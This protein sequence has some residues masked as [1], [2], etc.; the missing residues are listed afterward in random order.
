MIEGGDDSRIDKFLEDLSICAFGKIVSGSGSKDRA[1]DDNR[2]ALA[3]RRY[4]T[5][6]NGFLRAP[7]LIFELNKERIKANELAAIAAFST[8]GD[9]PEA[10]Q[11][12]FDLLQGQEDYDS[13]YELLFEPAI[14]DPNKEY[15]EV[16][17][18]TRGVAF[19]R[20]A[21]GEKVRV[22]GMSGEK[23]QVYVAWF[24][25]A[26]GVTEQAIRYRDL[27]GLADMFNAFRDAYQSKRCGDFYG[28]INDAGSNTTSLDTADVSGNALRDN[29]RLINKMYSTL[30]RRFYGQPGYGSATGQRVVYLLHQPEATDLVM[31]S[32]RSRFQS[33]DSSEMLVRYPVVPLMSLNAELWNGK[34]VEDVFMV[35]PGRKNK[36]H[37]ELAPTNYQEADP[38]SLSYVNYVWAAYCGCVGE[39]GQVEFASLL[40]GTTGP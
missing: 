6:L 11:S 26:M 38:C 9:F 28:L 17:T 21:E 4:S 33:F 7:Q 22:E 37:D 32:L 2:I 1:V 30:M 5:N 10:L 13:G 19:R 36:K 14:K 40:P 3:R 23:F 16:H 27:Q 39:A 34:N 25:A 35:I 20:M 18:I 24:A 15:F 29:A 8:K 31:G 12:N